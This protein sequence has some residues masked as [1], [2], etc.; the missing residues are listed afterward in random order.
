MSDNR[1]FVGNLKRSKIFMTNGL[2]K[3]ESFSNSFTHKSYSIV[4]ICHL[5]SL[6]EEN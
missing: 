1:T 5:K 2:I 4:T 6:I 3:S